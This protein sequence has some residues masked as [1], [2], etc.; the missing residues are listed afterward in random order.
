MF[1]IQC[2]L[3]EPCDLKVRCTNLAPGFRCEACPSG[4]E[5][6]HGQGV[7]VPS[8]VDHTF[9]RQTCNDIDECREGTARCATNSQCVNTEGSYDC[10]CSRGFS[11]NSTYGCLPVA[12]MCLDGTICDKNAVCKHSGSNTYRCKCK[13]GWAGDGHFC[14]P[15]KDLD[16]V[17]NLTLIDEFYL[18]VVFFLETVARL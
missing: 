4:Y 15:D 2:D 8:G 13:V 17:R 5:G 18:I 16:G 7:Y 10:M 11:R 1:L 12:G 6:Y 9:Q 14:G 3:I